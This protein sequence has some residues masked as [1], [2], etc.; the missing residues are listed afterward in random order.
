MCHNLNCPSAGAPAAWRATVPW[1][2][3]FYASRRNCTCKAYM[4]CCPGGHVMCG[5]QSTVQ[6]TLVM[7]TAEPH[8]R[9][10]STPHSEIQLCVMLNKRSLHGECACAT[11]SYDVPQTGTLASDSGCSQHSLYATIRTYQ[12]K[13]CFRVRDLSP[14]TPHIAA[15]DRC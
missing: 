10:P 13:R 7:P 2:M 3:P 5:L 4:L 9:P 15:V 11:K 12:S 8:A 14:R 6:L 1:Y